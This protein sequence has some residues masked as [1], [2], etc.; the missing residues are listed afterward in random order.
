MFGYRGVS[1]GECK[2]LISRPTL[3]V[4]LSI[5]RSHLLTPPANFSREKPECIT[6][7]HL[8]GAKISTKNSVLQPKIRLRGGQGAYISARAKGGP[9]I[10]SEALADTLC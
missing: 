5:F 4:A 1:L 3:R 8:A 7:F 10:I 2:A 6:N 9:S